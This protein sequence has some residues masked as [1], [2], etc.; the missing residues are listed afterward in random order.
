[1]N[2]VLSQDSGQI[3][4]I[5]S[6][7]RF[8]DISYTTQ[9]LWNETFKEYLFPTDI[10]HTIVVID[11]HVFRVMIQSPN[12]LDSLISFCNRKNQ[13]WVFGEY[14]VA[15]GYTE[16]S[17]RK[18]IRWIDSQVNAHSLLLF[19]EAEPS[20]RFY[21]SH[22][23]NIKTRVVQYWQ[24]H[25]DIRIRSQNI[26]KQNPNYDFLLTMRKKKSRPHRNLLWNE[27][28]SRNGLLDKGKT[29]YNDGE[30]WLGDAS[31]SAHT[32]HDGNP[33]MDL[34]LD[35][36]V[37]L[38]PE[39]LYNNIFF[40]TEKTWKPIATKTPFLT[41]TTAH[42]LDYLKS[43]GFKTFESLIDESYDKEYRIQDRIKLVV[44][45]LQYIVQNGAFEFY[46]ASQ[47][48]LDHNFQRLCEIHGSWHYNFDNV[49]AE[50]LAQSV[51]H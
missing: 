15:H 11:N 16:R 34:Y 43:N 38:V 26:K 47:H 17:V 1:M 31:A 6:F 4:S 37:E 5:T 50:E 35:C 48:I 10:E 3:D 19:L 51:A 13:L 20:N 21:L 30:V 49:I 39:T 28:Q 46:Q 18:K 12:T 23:T 32:W 24:W 36:C 41:V 25:T 45:Q 29:S 2:I 14:D 27:L 8:N 42:Y 22:L 40:F 44:D 9:S 33:S 7:L